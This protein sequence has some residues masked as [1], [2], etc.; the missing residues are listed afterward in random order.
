MERRR[1]VQVLTDPDFS[2]GVQTPGHPPS[3][4]TTGIATGQPNSNSLL[5]ND[6]AAQQVVKVNDR[7]VT[8]AKSTLYPPDLQ[9]AR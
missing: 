4:A 3:P 6:I 8:S 7:I 2:V 1:E 5:D 9:S